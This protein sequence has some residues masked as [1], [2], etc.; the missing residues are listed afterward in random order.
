ML[1]AQ[2]GNDDM[3]ALLA[4]NQAD[5]TLQD[6]EGRG[7]YCMSRQMLLDRKRQT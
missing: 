4:E 6:N 2:L 5:M 3:M 7:L 1:A